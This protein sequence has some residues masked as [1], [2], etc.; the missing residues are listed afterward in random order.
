M[1]TQ[2][3][4]LT[5]I[6][7][8]IREKEASTA[9]IPAN[10]FADRILALPVGIESPDVTLPAASTQEEQLARIAAAIRAKEGSEGTIPAAEF[11]ERILALESTKPSRLP[12]GYTEVEYIQFDDKTGFNTGLY[13]TPSNT[14]V[15]L[16]ILVETAY[17]GAEEQFASMLGSKAGQSTVS[18]YMLSFGRTSATQTYI[19]TGDTSK[20]AIVN[21]SIPKERLI[22]KFD[23][24]K[25]KFSVGTVSGSIF[26]YTYN[27]YTQYFY[28]GAPKDTWKSIPY[29]LYGATIQQGSTLSRDFVPCINPQKTVGLYDLV[30]GAFYAN[31]LTGTVTAGP[32]V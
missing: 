5:A 31:A 14:I 18:N 8:A 9:V 15:T 16:D 22:V 28:I 17:P 26:K 10:T 13:V 32:R 6:A 11:A 1:S 2:E 21:V 7:D 25:S 3:T 4:N 24:T 12:A 27:L 19:R 30:K 23:G 29:K 20:I